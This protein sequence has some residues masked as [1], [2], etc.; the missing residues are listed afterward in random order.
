MLTAAQR[1]QLDLVVDRLFDLKQSRWDSEKR[2][3]VLRF[4][5]LLPDG[6]DL[7]EIEGWSRSIQLV[8]FGVER[9]FVSPEGTPFPPELP[10]GE[11]SSAMMSILVDVFEEQPIYEWS[12]FSSPDRHFTKSWQRGWNYATPE[13][14][15]NLE[16]LAVF[17][18]KV[19]VADGAVWILGLWFRELAIYPDRVN[20]DEPIDIDT[21]LAA[22]YATAKNIQP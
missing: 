15:P 5:I 11:V 18:E 9:L 19:G 22:H 17:K 13:Y 12:M 2:R 21:F 20:D 1:S 4:D 6:Q 3:V 14:R 7:P 10:P 16:Y 8:A